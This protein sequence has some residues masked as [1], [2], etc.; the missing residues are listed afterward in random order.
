MLEK[1]KR[2][3]NERERSVRLLDLPSLPNL[4]LEAASTTA[5]LVG[6]STLVGWGLNIDILKR[7]LPGLVAMNP[8]TA[9][10]FILAGVLGHACG[11]ELLTEIARRIKGRL[12]KSDT[13]ARLGGDEFAIILEG[14]AYAQDAALVARDI[15]DLISQPTVLDGHEI[16]MTGSIG[17]AV[18]PRRRGIGCSRTPTPPCT[19]P[20]GGAATTMSSTRR[21]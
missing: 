16:F 15:L 19:A 7:I 21:R 18:R 2:V 20:R 8:V 5:I 6:C 4:M 14:L 17:I 3:Q 12:R 9:I 10:A 13:V 11:G 1:R